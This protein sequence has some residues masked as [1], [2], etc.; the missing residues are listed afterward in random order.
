[1]NDQIRQLAGLIEDMMYDFSAH[2]LDSE[3]CENISHG[4]YR[5]LRALARVNMCAMQDIAKNIAVTKSGATRIISRLEEK[6]LVRRVQNQNDGRVCCVQ[7]SKE[8]QK[9]ISEITKQPANKITTVLAAMDP[10]MRQI[11]LTSLNAFFQTAN[12]QFA[13]SKIRRSK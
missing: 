2:N 9:R 7:L 10:N 6:K 12:D 8:G 5:A 4:E 11:L 3:C 13:N 1:M